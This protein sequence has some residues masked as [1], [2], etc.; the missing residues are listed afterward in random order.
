MTRDRRQRAR[1]YEVLLREGSPADLERW[2]DGAL[3]VD[4]W[5]D[6]VVPRA[7][8]AAWRPVL[9]FDLSRS[10]GVDAAAS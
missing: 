3:L 1:L 4:A 8:R 10:A 7:V 2:V 9:E 6:M 5:E